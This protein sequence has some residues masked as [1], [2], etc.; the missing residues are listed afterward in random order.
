VPGQE[1]QQ[2]CKGINKIYRN[3]VLLSK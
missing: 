3:L 1:R 2:G